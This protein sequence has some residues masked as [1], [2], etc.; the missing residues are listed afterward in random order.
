MNVRN[1]NIEMRRKNKKIKEK[2]SLMG[3]RIIL[4][5]YISLY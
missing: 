4:N 1:D 5:Y 3:M 2:V